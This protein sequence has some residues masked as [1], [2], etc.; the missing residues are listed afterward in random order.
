MI[1][2]GEGGV[3]A[4]RTFIWSLANELM[5]AQHLDVA[6]IEQFKELLV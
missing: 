2:L 4:D 5:P 6:E 3:G 1:K